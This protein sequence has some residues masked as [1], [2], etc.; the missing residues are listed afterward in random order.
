MKQTRCT[1]PVKR[2]SAYSREDTYDNY[3]QWD[4]HFY[5]R[6]LHV[7]H[8]GIILCFPPTPSWIS[9][10]VV[11]TTKTNI[12]LPFQSTNSNNISCPKSI[13][14]TYTPQLKSPVVPFQLAS[15]VDNFTFSPAI[16]LETRV[17]ARALLH[18]LIIL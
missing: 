5:T 8:A 3:C 15:V 14:L 12:I 11:G 18:T 7:I 13:L 17:R 4:K 6:Y 2:L 10:I 9:S 16:P 1:F